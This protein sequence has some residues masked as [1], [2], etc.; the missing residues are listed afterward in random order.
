M[1]TM[2]F[3]IYAKEFLPQEQFEKPWSRTHTKMQ[4]VSY[5]CTPTLRMHVKEQLAIN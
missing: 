1:V 5:Y 4:R 2:I 3:L